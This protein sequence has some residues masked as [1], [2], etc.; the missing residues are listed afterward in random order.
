MNPKFQPH[1]RIYFKSNHPA[2]IIDE[3][4][5]YYVFHRVTSSSKSG[6]HPNWKVS[7]NPN[8]RR[9]TPMYIIKSKQK[10]KKKRFGKNLDW[11][12]NFNFQNKKWLV[13]YN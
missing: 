3:D 12:T 9:E 4:G 2:Y 11:N 10:D 8:K 5:E 1:F 13:Q 6:H 7:P